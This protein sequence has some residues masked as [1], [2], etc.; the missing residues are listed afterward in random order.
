MSTGIQSPKGNEILAMIKA[1]KEGTWVAIKP[2]CTS[3][4]LNWAGQYDKLNGN[5]KFNCMDIQMVGAD[6]RRRDMLCLPAEQVADWI[7]SINSNKVSEE[8]AKTLLELQKFFQAGLNELARGRL[9]TEADVASIVRAEMEPLLR[10]YA[11]VVERY[12]ALEQE[13]AVY[14]RFEDADSSAAASRMSHQRWA[15]RDRKLYAVS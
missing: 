7:S 2:L 9:M 15:N 6:G 14:R 13:L 3:L 11:D 12:K 1:T 5:R 10:A 8:K 4:K